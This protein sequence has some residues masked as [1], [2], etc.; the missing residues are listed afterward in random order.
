MS[1]SS[2]LAFLA[3]LCEPCQRESRQWLNSLQA[4]C[5]IDQ[6]KSL[7]LTPSKLHL[8][9]TTIPKSGMREVWCVFS[10]T[11]CPSNLASAFHFATWGRFNPEM[12]SSYKLLA[13]KWLRRKSRMH[14][15]S[16]VQSVEPQQSIAQQALMPKRLSR[17]PWR[18]HTR[19]GKVG[20]AVPPWLP[21]LV[22]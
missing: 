18:M 14:N 1:Q 10:L 6:L 4:V 9:R 22:G 13:L 17:K 7:G 11:F 8:W 12:R 21:A 3:K 19:K 2:E 20:E 5:S 16:Y 15:M